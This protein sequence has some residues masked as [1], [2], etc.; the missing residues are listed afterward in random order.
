MK[1]Q[2]PKPKPRFKHTEN[3]TELF[4]FESFIYKANKLHLTI[5]SK[6]LLKIHYNYDL[7]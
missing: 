6:T 2:W 7:E 4:E 3:K 1:D 5:W